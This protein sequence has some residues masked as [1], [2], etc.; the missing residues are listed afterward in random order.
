MKCFELET[1]L[2]YY[3]NY[4]YIYLFETLEEEQEIWVFRFEINCNIFDY[5][6][7]KK[8]QKVSADLKQ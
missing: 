6:P 1:G 3:N 8:G 2:H 7:K 5:L 4:N